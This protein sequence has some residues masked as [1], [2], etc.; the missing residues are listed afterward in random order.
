MRSFDWDDLRIFL[1]AAR[2][3][4]VLET[5]HRLQMSQ[6]TISRRL[7]KLESDTGFK[8]FERSTGGLTL[9]G[10]GMSLLERVEQLES[11]LL[12]IETDVFDEALKLTGEIRIGATEAFGTCFLTPHLARFCSR[13]PGISV[14]VLPMPR[15]INLGKREADLLVTIDRP[16]ASSYVTSQLTNYRLQPYATQEYLDNH[17]PIVDVDSLV[18][19]VW[20]DYVDDLIFSPQQFSLG[21]WNPLIKPK[22]RSTSVIAQAE[23]AKAG[24]GIAMLPCFLGGPIEELVPIHLENVEIFRTFWLVAPPDRRDLARVLSVWRY[25]SEVAKVNQDFFMGLVRRTNFV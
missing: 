19:Q 8:L 3:Q 15:N 25:I 14:D 6:S 9:T 2:A 17:P 12:S 11:T 23:A 22:F 10:V 1:A 18:K 7:Q 5:S 16:S 4:S 21:K 24:F 20:I 13:H